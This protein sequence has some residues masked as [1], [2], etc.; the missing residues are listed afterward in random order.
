MRIKC[1]W[2]VLAIMMAAMLSLGL[3]SCGGDGDDD[4]NGSGGGGDNISEQWYFNGNPGRAENMKIKIDATKFFGNELVLNNIIN[5]T[6]SGISS[7]VIHIID[8]NTLQVL[9]DD[10]V[11][12]N[13]NGASGKQLLYRWSSPDFGTLDFYCS[14]PVTYTYDRYEDNKIY[15]Y[16]WGK[17]F[18]VAGNML[19]MD[20]GDTFYTYDPETEYVN[21]N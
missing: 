8:K 13:G 21:V 12:Q 17:F 14:N 20:G 10:Y 18:T 4:N 16:T 11:C 5:G 19:I 1:F 7:C 15:V 3:T 2:S 9:S 6:Y